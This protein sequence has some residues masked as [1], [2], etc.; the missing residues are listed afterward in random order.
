M[1]TVIEQEKDICQKLNRSDPC[2]LKAL[3]D[4]FVRFELD[5]HMRPTVHPLLIRALFIE[6]VS[7]ER[8]KLTVKGNVGITTS[9]RYR[10]M[11]INFF[12]IRYEVAQ[13]QAEV[14]QTSAR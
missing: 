10:H 14:A 4:L 3:D 2:A 7:E 1:Q 11:Y 6:Q 5:D 8:W 13:K 9:Y 12:N